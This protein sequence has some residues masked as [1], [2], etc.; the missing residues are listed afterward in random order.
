VNRRDL[1]LGFGGIAAA[2]LVA[3]AQQQPMPVV[4]ILD[5]ADPAPFLSVFRNALRD[6]GFVEGQN[7]RLEVLSAM[8]DPRRVRQL[9]D[10]LVRLKVDVIVTRLNLPTSA[11]KAATTTIPIVMAPGGAPIET[12]LI[13]SLSHPG[14]NVTGASVSSAELGGKRMQLMREMLPSLRRL[15]VLGNAKDT[16]TGPLVAEIETAGHT[17]GITVEP[18]MVASAEDFA[19]AFAT[20]ARHRV[21]AVIMQAS[22]P[23]K[24]MVELAVARRITP[25]ATTPAGVADGALM[26]YSASWQQAY[27]E[28]A[29]YVAKILKGARP[30]DLPVEE[31][32][33]FELVINLKTAKVLGLTVPQLLLV[34]A[35]EV[36]E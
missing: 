3:R 9:A 28:A 27:R 20:M 11:A 18:I 22:L 17:L 26:A 6:Q 19:S 33:K 24:P 32:T 4:G 36:I 7:V 16:F 13:A 10:E 23:M 14:G 29:A 25:F 1:L 31:P 21:D 15:V 35:D 5:V 8:G 2:P 12:G 30:G 34:Q